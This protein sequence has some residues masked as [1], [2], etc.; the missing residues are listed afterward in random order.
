MHPKCPEMT[1]SSHTVNDLNKIPVVARSVFR[2]TVCCFD[3]SDS[4][5]VEPALPA[6]RVA[7][8]S[9]QASHGADDVARLKCQVDFQNSQ[10]WIDDLRVASTWRFHGIGRQLAAAAER[11]AWAL[12]LQTV[13]VFPLMSAG[14]FWRKMGYTSH[15]RTARVVTKNLPEH[16]PAVPDGCEKTRKPTLS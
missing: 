16:G 13:N 6:V 4:V 8:A 14:C 3:E 2:E 15:P 10:M 5:S 12:G 9:A 7:Y 1:S 11:I